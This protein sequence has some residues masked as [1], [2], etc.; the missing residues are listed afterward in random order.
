MT[1][2]NLVLGRLSSRGLL[3]GEMG[4]DASLSRAAFAP[5]AARL[6]FGVERTAH[7][8]LGIVVANM[9]RAIRTISVER[10]YDPR[11]FTLMAFGGAGPL[12]AREVA[13]AL[14]MRE[15]LVPAAPGIL[16][17]QGLI[18]SDLQE[19]FVAS[20][21]IGG[22]AA[23]LR[24]LARHVETLAARARA[25][26]EAEEVPVR[27]RRLDLAVDARYVG[28]NFELVV[29]V[30]TL[31]DGAP[32]A[33]GAP[34]AIGDGGGI[35]IPS[36]EALRERFLEVHEAAYGYAN[37]H[38]PIEIVNVRLTARGRLL[39]EPAP[40][41]PG[42]PG[43]LPEPFERRTVRWTAEHATDCPVHDRDS[44]R[45]GHALEG[46]AIIEQL[47]STI[48]IFPGDRA[49]LDRAGNLVIHVAGGASAGTSS[50]APARE[51]A[52]A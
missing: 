8:V 14:G 35:P 27:S 9:V 32:G 15:I 5:V 17:A 16:C 12:H 42:D 21:R 25:W 3:A 19:A 50:D 20:D 23:G 4:L 6:G 22:D 41:E 51:E 24:R 18:V 38:D 49:V 39:E 44:L 37:P 45:P 7:G 40:P 34:G 11:G 47:D 33:P 1:D 10:G 31:G 28:Q 13:L 52:P 46:P 48:P 2:A 43:P 29:P 26:F 36:P 30:A